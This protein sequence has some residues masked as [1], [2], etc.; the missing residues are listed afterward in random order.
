[1]ENKYD[2]IFDLP[3]LLKLGDLDIRGIAEANA[4]L[5]VGEYYE[6][7]RGFIHLAPAVSAA[8]NRFV[9]R[10]AD[11]NSCRSIEDMIALSEGLGYDKFNPDFYH[12]LDAYGKGDWRL[13]AT[14][15]KRILNGFDEL[16]SRTATAKRRTRKLEVLP[17]DPDDVDEPL[18]DSHTA[19][20]ETLLW[21]FLKHLDEEETN[22]K[23]LILVVD[24]SPVI[25]KSVSAVLS[26][27]YKVLTLA[28]P[29]MLE[30]MLH[31]V[32]PELFLL[33]FQMP[34]INGFDLVPVIRSFKE[35]KD[36][37]IIYLTSGGT[38]D[39]VTAAFMLGASDFIVKPVK[40]EL[41]REKIAKHIVR[42][43]KF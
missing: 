18:Y 43:K 31:Q 12:I 33:D 28:K 19:Q 39:N 27:D 13:A 17:G 10:D 35:H 8:L 24:D 41:L 30:K 14:Y 32:T 9:N 40:P 5:S 34:E 6:T 36:T 15:A 25:L 1:M 16:H 11:K 38:T 29:T 4:S 2:V 20:G 37:P 26:V 21:E 23:L 3:A 7:L 22:R 42:K